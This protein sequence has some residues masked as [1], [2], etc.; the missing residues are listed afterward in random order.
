[1]RSIRAKLFVSIGSIF[2]V[3]SV[4]SY[5]VPAFFIREDIDLASDYLNGMYSQYVK[6]LQKLSKSWV[7]YRVIHQAA[8]LDMVSQGI[9]ISND[10]L[11]KMANDVLLKD[12]NLAIVQVTKNEETFVISPESGTPF[13]P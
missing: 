3:I 1:M 12:P 5:F 11:W 2:L 13:T 9:Q 4:L 10:P 6:K 7:T 8:Q